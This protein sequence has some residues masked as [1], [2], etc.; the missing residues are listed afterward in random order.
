MDA[1]PA[2][3]PRLPASDFAVAPDEQGSARAL[4]AEIPQLMDK[5]RAVVKQRHYAARTENAYIEWIHQFLRFCP[6]RVLASLGEA[7]LRAFLEQVS[8]QP[9]VGPNVCNQARA[10]LVLLF[11]A[12]LGQQL[13]CSDGLGLAPAESKG[14]APLAPAELERL[15]AA[16][17]PA[18]TLVIA[19]LA[20]TDLRPAETLALRVRDIDLDRG[21]ISVR[22][23]RSSKPARQVVLPAALVDAFK[24]HLASGSARHQLD[25]DKKAGFATLPDAARLADPGARRSFAWQWLFP[26]AQISRDHLTGEGRRRHQ[27]TVVVQRALSAA[28]RAAGLTRPVTLQTLRI[29]S[30]AE[31]EPAR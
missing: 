25:L 2:S 5:V 7:D 31:R 24:A 17:D 1:T 14:A 4:A 3:T 28:A 20:A 27:E 6:G 12:V 13:D 15:M 16:V 10:A 26:A 9:G 19:L 29:G 11:H 18:Q 8:A 21:I 22:D 23:E 30:R